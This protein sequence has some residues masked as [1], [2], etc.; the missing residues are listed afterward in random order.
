[1]KEISNVLIEAAV[2][3]VPKKKK[4]ESTGSREADH[5]EALKRRSSVTP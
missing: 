1:M 3:S 2:G 4:E 5:K